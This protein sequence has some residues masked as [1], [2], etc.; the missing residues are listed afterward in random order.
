MRSIL[1]NVG[2][3]KLNFWDE[4][5]E[6]ETLSI[7]NNFSTTINQFCRPTIK[8]V[9]IST[10]IA[11]E[12]SCQVTFTGNILTSRGLVGIIPARLLTSEQPTSPKMR[13][14]E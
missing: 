1:R 4:P 14:Y 6:R 7:E 2:K 13:G 5:I 11:V 9:W 8:E 12:L 3:S 10:G